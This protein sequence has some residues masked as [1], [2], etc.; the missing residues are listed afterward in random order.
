MFMVVLSSHVWPHTWG[1]TWGP[2]GIPWGVLAP[3]LLFIPAEY[4]HALCLFLWDLL[5][6]IPVREYNKSRY[7]GVHFGSAPDTP[8]PLSRACTGPIL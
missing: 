8:R 5:Y 2:P 3:L 4:I 1:I 7:L 6:S